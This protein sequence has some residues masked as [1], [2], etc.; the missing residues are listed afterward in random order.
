MRDID[1]LMDHVRECE[2]IRGPIIKQA[3]INRLEAP[4]TQEELDVARQQLYGKHDSFPESEHTIAETRNT[5][6]RSI[7]DEDMKPIERDGK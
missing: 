3:I 4:P 7:L 6:G 2:Y 1:R 5:D